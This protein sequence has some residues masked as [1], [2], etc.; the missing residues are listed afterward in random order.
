MKFHHAIACFRQHGQLAAGSALAALTVLAAP[1]MAYEVRAEAKLFN[2]GHNQVGKIRLT[3]EASGNVAVH[4]TVHDLTPGFH[5]FHVHAVGSCTVEKDVPPFTSAGGHFD[6]GMNPH[7]NHAG[8]FPV[9]LV[10]SDG[11]ANVKFNTDRF[12]IDA[13]FDGDG[14]AIIIHANRD[15]YANI[16][17]RYTAAG[18]STPGPD[19]ATLATGDSGGRV[20]CGVLERIVRRD[21]GRG[22]HHEK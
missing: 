15:N 10:Q 1:A 4:V 3:Q 6:L 12:T 7:G 8:D 17:D 2:A 16:P 22:E 18:A 9:L 21:N 14:S 19:A 11:T 5:G 13:L 20:A